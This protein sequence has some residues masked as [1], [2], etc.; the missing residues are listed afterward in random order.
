LEKSANVSVTVLKASICDFDMRVQRTF[1][2][3]QE[4]LNTGLGINCHYNIHNIKTTS[5]L[6]LI[7]IFHR[8]LWA[9][10]HVNLNQHE[11]A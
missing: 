5:Q 3:M 6:F 9:I 7:Y 1:K 10:F 8:Y 2:H 4:T 11:F